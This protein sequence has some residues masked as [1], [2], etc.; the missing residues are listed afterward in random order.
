L[1]SDACESPTGP[2][3]TVALPEVTVIFQFATCGAGA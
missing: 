2:E 1:A 3:N